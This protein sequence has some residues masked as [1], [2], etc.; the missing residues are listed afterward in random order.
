MVE[1]RF[2]KGDF[3]Y[4]RRV[5]VTNDDDVV[6]D[7][8]AVGLTFNFVVWDEYAPTTIL[9]TVGVDLV[10]GI[11]GEVDLDIVAGDFNAAGTYL[12]KVKIYDGVISKEGSK[13]VR[14]VVEESA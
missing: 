11:A 13:T 3:G 2:N 4:K 6:I 5:I 12:G 8:S 9:W 7:L 1:L 14:V 10:S